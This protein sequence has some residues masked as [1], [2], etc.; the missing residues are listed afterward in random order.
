VAADGLDHRL[1]VEAAEKVGA[2]PETTLTL[3]LHQNEGDGRTLGRFRLSATTDPG[4]VAT[5][6]GP[7]LTPELIEAAA[8]PCADRTREQQGALNGFFRRLTPELAPARAAL[9]AAELRKAE[10]VREI[11]QSL[12]TSTEDPEPVR[13][14][15]RG[16]WLDDSGE[17]V[18][19]AVPHFLPPL[20]TG[21]RRPTRLD[22]ARWLTSA[23][24][25]LTARV[26]VNR[27]WKLFFG[28][29]LVRSLEDLGS[30]GEWPSHPE[31]LDWLAVEFVESGW[32]VK[33]LVRTLVTSAA[34]RQSARAPAELLARDPDNRLHARQARFR[35][36]AEM[37]RDN[38][39]AVSGLL[40]PAMGG[41][42]AR[43]YQPKG[44]W[45]YLNFPPREWDD[46]P[47][48][49]QY[50]RGI[51]TWWQRT[52]PQPSLVAFDAVSREECVAERTRSNVPQQA[53]VLLND[54]TYVEAARVFAERILRDGGRDF[55]GR[56]RW[57]YERALA[58]SPREEEGHILGELLRNHVAQYRADRRAAA[59]LASAGQSP[60]LNGLD[61]VELAGWTSVARAI[62]NLPEVITRP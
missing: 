33:R 22:L 57:A 15:P 44:Y 24:N 47:G 43:P 51:Y 11:P 36:D 38:A 53:L 40:S 18:D 62:L 46:S 5:G 58:R 54:P 60:A 49:E 26:F 21:G 12:V 32:D 31:L 27:V 17:V 39:L 25:P 13:V 50:R 9:R 4:P 10:L 42:A 61:T 19:P 35:L 16:N 6:P 28:Q 3:T 45:A 8:K 2:G 55:D 14:L 23:E 52:F 1:V 56:L 34:Y 41:P 20:D 29:G 7:A 37:V 48:E 59:L 30:Q